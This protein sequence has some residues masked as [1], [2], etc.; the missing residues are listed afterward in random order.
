VTGI[1]DQIETIEKDNAVR[2]SCKARPMILCTLPH[3][4]EEEKKEGV[5]RYRF[6]PSK[7][8]KREHYDGDEEE[9]DN[10]MKR[11]VELWPFVS[12]FK[13]VIKWQTAH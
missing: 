12:L 7:S 13:S 6:A 4:A 11:V 1:A 3:T 8:I 5:G 2:A 9:D 10:D